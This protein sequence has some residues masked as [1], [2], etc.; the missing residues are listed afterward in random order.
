EMILQG[1][2]LGLSVI[3]FSAHSPLWEGCSWAL[4]AERVSDYRREI[5]RLRVKYA[6][7]IRV[8]CGIERDAL[9]D[10]PTDDFDY[11][12]GSV[13]YVCKNGGR[14]SV[15]DSA[16]TALEGI[17]RYFDGDIYA[18]AEEY[19]RT[20]G[21]IVERTNADLIGHFDLLTKFCDCGLAFDPQNPRYLAAWQASADRLLKTGVPFEIN[22]G[23]ISRGYRKTPYP[24]PDIMRYLAEHGGKAVITSDSH[25]TGA[26]GCA[27]ALAYRLAKET[28]L[29]L[30]NKV[31]HI[32]F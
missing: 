17:E 11:V 2:R 19:F 29:P 22:T 31:K 24:A 20:V 8:Y 25:S 9:T 26:L 30:V 3:G 1:I 28:G 18:Y 21:E 32:E 14:I 6:D 10:V 15:D 5:E 4:P 12:I 13:H 7:R 27:Y 23:A 16:K